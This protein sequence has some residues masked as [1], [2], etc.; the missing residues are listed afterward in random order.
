MKSHFTNRIDERLIR[1]MKTWRGCRRAA[2]GLVCLMFAGEV[3]AV[4]LFR[5]VPLPDDGRGSTARSVNGGIIIFPN[6]RQVVGSRT[7][8]SGMSVPV[9]WDVNLMTDAAVAT[10][11]PLPAGD[12]GEALGGATFSNGDMVVVGNLSL[13]GQPWGVFWRKPANGT[14]SMP[15]VLCQDSDQSWVTRSVYSSSNPPC[16]IVAG[17]S[18][19]GGRWRAT[20]HFVTTSDV[21]TV[22]LPT[23]P[24]NSPNSAAL[25]VASSTGEVAAGGWV[26]DRQGRMRPVLW[27][28]SGQGWSIF[29]IGLA[30]GAQGQVNDVVRAD[31]RWTAV[32][33]NFQAARTLGF[34]VDDV[35]VNAPTMLLQPLDG[36]ANS[37]ALDL[38]T[39]A[40][41]TFGT[42]Y[43]PGGNPPAATGWFSGATGGGSPFPSQQL[44][45]DPGSVAEV[46]G[47]EPSDAENS[48]VG[49]IMT[50]SGGQP[51]ACFFPA[52][53]THVPDGINAAVGNIIDFNNDGFPDFL[54]WHKDGNSL[55]VR[56]ERSG[57]MRKAMFD[58]QFTPLFRPGP[59]AS[60]QFDLIVRAEGNQPGA[61][62]TLDVYT[63]DLASGDWLPLGSFLVTSTDSHF[64]GNIPT[65]VIQNGG[66]SGIRLR[67]EFTGKGNQPTALVCDTATVTE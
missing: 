15:Q 26:T 45:L 46:R 28:N 57:G 31:S 7:N 62:G 17:S 14:W 23:S 51:Q 66:A 21:L 50:T 38:T 65:A 59:P 10:E 13:N 53:N 42:S 44:L 11:L 43:N 9:I 32:G 49:Q 3:R 27:V 25:A 40:G 61:G 63:L 30:N 16:L 60:A 48:T 8:A 54:L 37:S 36:Y 67:L 64:S 1:K 6:I 52:T 29:P 19:E 33:V 22:D 55:R 41:V 12:E 56:T 2:L 18:L 20:L 4:E 35:S 5:A 58:L 34:R 39:D 47:F 24:G